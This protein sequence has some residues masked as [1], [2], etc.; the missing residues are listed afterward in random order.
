MGQD[1]QNLGYNDFLPK[2]ASLNVA[3]DAIKASLVEGR[4]VARSSAAGQSTPI[5]AD[6]KKEI[7]AAQAGNIESLKT[8]YLAAAKERDLAS[9][10]LFG[11]N[12]RGPNANAISARFE[13]AAEARSNAEEAMK[14]AARAA[15]VPASELPVYTSNN[16]FS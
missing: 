6:E 9:K 13:A 3:G 16:S 4:N 14:S 8:A 1:I 12:A 5:I 10:E 2:M 15:G 11:L 7:S